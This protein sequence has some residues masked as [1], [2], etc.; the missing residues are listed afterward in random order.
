MFNVGPL[1]QYTL[2]SS[3]PLTSK[4]SFVD[5]SY[6]TLCTRSNPSWRSSMRRRRRRRMP[7]KANSRRSFNSSVLRWP[8]YGSQMTTSSQRQGECESDQT[9]LTR[10]PC[11]SKPVSFDEAKSASVGVARGRA[12]QG[13]FEPILGALMASMSNTAIGV[14]TKALKGLSGIVSIDP[15]ILSQVSDN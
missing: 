8:R 12:L 11:R 13:A 4:R 6:T 3:H 15:A 7:S 5:K 2:T 1:S 14:R 10:L 9:E